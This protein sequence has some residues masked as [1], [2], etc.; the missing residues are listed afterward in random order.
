MSNQ[1]N[2]AAA[3]DD[4][5][6]DIEALAVYPHAGRRHVIIAVDLGGGDWRAALSADVARAF[7]DAIKAAAA[8]VRSK[9]GAS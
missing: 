6:S 4:R 9:G 2:N 3:L 8:A 1:A 5:M 7:A